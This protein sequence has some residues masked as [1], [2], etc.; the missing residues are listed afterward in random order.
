MR[1]FVLH[2][3]LLALVSL[4]ASCE[5]HTLSN[6]SLDG[7]WQLSQVDTLTTS[8]S[9]DMVPRRIFWSVQ[10]RLLQVSDLNY[11][12]D[13]CILRFEHA[14]G[15]L[16][17]FSPYVVDHFGQDVTVDDAEQLHPFGI[18]QTDETFVVEQLNDDALVLRG[19]VLRLSFRRY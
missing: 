17:V 7:F 8:G 5:F 18:Q 11:V 2:I 14:D 4:C 19:S 3:L 13:E 9:T 1:R 12:H 16:R 15:R 6:G 10:A